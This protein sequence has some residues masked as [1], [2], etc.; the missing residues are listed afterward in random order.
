MLRSD[1]DLSKEI[2]FEDRDP[3]GMLRIN[4][5]G[6]PN[7]FSN[8]WRRLRSHKEMEHLIIVNYRKA[9]RFNYNHL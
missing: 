6:Y 4:V 8:S 9:I 1:I 3:V 5:K 2:K 7:S